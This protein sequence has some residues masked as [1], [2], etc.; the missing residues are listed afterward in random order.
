[1]PARNVEDPENVVCDQSS[2]PR[3]GDVVS[4]LTRPTLRPR[5]GTIQRTREPT[6]RRSP[7]FRGARGVGN[8]SASRAARKRRASVEHP[9][10]L[11]PP[12]FTQVADAPAALQSRANRRYPWVQAVLQRPR[13]QSVDAALLAHAEATGIAADAIPKRTTV[14]T[15]VRRFNAFGILGLLDAVRSDAGSKRVLASP[16]I[17]RTLTA[18]AVDEL[19]AIIICGAKGKTIDVVHVLNRRLKRRGIEIPYATGWR[20]VDDWRRR[21]PHDVHIAH[22]GEGAFAEDA[23]LHL[24]MAP[25]APGALHSFDSSPADEW[26]RV[27]D[28]KAPLGWRV[29][30]PI[31]T[32]V[33]DVGS[34]VAL[35]FEVCLGAVT[36][37]VVRSA[38]R[39]CYCPGENW[40]GLPTV[41]MPTR[42]IAD[43]GSEHRDEVEAVFTEFGLS[44]KGMPLPPEAHAHVERVHRT[45]NAQTS[46]AELGRTTT[47]R[48]A[49]AD[50]TSTREH[51]RSRKARAREERRP[52][53]PMMAL[54][55]LADYVQA[56]RATMVAYNCAPHRGITRDL[57]ARGPEDRAA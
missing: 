53:V 15:W 43:M 10:T 30:R 19:I 23:R 12:S 6:L 26:V 46:R 48:I 29:D 35:S 28:E 50:D 56:C 45:L 37:G 39:R 17:P 36:S 4:S 5:V 51:A 49:G 27:R 1:M 38:L 42:V 16:A 57:R 40:E 47:A 2:R 3:D 52:E 33:L 7:R 20:W 41:T 34:R 21:H 31:V 14:L 11:R 24:G 9:D 32:R 44:T 25:M 54:R 8:A 13:Q 18:E 22:E 55:T